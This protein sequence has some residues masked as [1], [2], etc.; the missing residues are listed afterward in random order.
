MVNFFLF[1]SINY[2]GVA[3]G[4]CVDASTVCVFWGLEPGDRE[5]DGER[6]ERGREGRQKREGKYLF[7][8]DLRLFA[9][10]KIC[11]QLVKGTFAK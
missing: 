1:L 3:P 9:V 7:L 5:R 10:Q 6:R 2:F 11:L 8:R 4:V